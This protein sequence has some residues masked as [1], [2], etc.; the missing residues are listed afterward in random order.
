MKSPVLLLAFNRPD[1]TRQIFQAIRAAQPPKLYVAVDGPRADRRTD[2][3]L[4]DE[5]LAIVG[6]VDWECEVHT[7]YEPTNLGC[8]TAVSDAI[9]WMLAAEGEGIILE[10]D[11]LPCPS[12]FDYCDVMLDRYREDPTVQVVSGYNPVV[13]LVD[14]GQPYSFSNFPMI[15]G[16]ATWQR[17][18]DDYDVA[19]TDWT[20]ARSAEF[21]AVVAKSKQATEFWDDRFRSIQDGRVD[22]WDYQLVEL[23]WRSG[24][25]AALPAESLI[26]NLGF[27]ADATHTSS[28][29]PRHVRETVLGSFD[30]SGAHAGQP[31][32]H[33]STTAQLDKKLQQRFFALGLTPALRGMLRR[34]LRR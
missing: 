16:W 10:D 3:P 28:A 34:V 17:T 30:P 25:Y 33:R 4:R 6:E 18:W 1:T 20:S 12:F 13:G 11:T 15:W 26:V 29:P 23:L 2:A 27:R 22:T 32:D 5:V 7:K 31:A 9:S 19:L 14:S 24:G 21:P 8:K